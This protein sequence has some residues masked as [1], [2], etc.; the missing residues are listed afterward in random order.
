MAGDAGAKRRVR[1][2]DEATF[3]DVE[4]A[5]FVWH[6]DQRRRGF[7]VTGEMLTEKAKTAFSILH[8]RA[9]VR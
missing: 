2:K 9:K 3:P 6:Q 4:K 1:A 8:P 7:S 5:T